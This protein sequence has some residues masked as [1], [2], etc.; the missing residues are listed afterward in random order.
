MGSPKTEAIKERLREM[1]ATNEFAS[2]W[3]SAI[4]R[5]ADE[6]AK[7]AQ[8][9]AGMKDFAL[10][11]GGIIARAKRAVEEAVRS[12]AF[13]ELSRIVEEYDHNEEEVDA[14]G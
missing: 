6:D 1:S 5:S 14:S 3:L 13:Q 9:E 11:L 10:H 12:P 2:N 7:V 4:E 8:I